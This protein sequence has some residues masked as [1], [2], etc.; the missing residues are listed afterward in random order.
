MRGGRKAETLMRAKRK[1]TLDVQ[2]PNCE[3]EGFSFSGIQYG[4]GIVPDMEL[5]TCT[6]C[7][8]TFSKNT[9]NTPSI[10]QNGL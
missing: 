3:N 10:P 9:M 6:R 2:C 4:Y 5:W 8:S 1:F 7:G